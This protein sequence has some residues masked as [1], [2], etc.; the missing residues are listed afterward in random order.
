MG[1]DIVWLGQRMGRP[2]RRFLRAYSHKSR[3]FFFD[4]FLEDVDPA[5]SLLGRNDVNDPGVLLGLF[6]IGSFDV[7]LVQRR[8]SIQLLGISV[9]LVANQPK[10]E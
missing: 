8:T 9:V 6:S 3:I 7:R 2:Q 4:L 5:H 1:I 10:V